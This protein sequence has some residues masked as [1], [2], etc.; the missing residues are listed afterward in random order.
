MPT[1]FDEK[2]NLWRRLTSRGVTSTTDRIFEELYSK[3]DKKQ[4]VRLEKDAA[5]VCHDGHDI[6]DIIKNSLLNIL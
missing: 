3:S 1:E 2:Y 5:L 6:I 4:R